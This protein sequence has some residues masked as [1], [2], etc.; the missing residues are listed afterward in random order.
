MDLADLPHAGVLTRLGLSAIHGIGVFAICPIAKGTR[1][2]AHDEAHIRWVD[3]AALDLAAL[4]PAERQLY[5]DFAIRRDGMLG[6]PTSFDQLTPG[7]YLNE[8][9]D[10]G[11]GNVRLTGDFAVIA[12]RDIREGEE[13]TCRYASFNSG[14]AWG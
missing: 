14:P 7:W 8:P 10:G 2:F 11:A 4:R 3:A 5:Q 1:V 12:D 9:A 13:L 6:C